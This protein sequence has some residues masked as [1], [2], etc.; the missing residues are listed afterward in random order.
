MPVSC[1]HTSV[2]KPSVTNLTWDLLFTAITKHRCK[3]TSWPIGIKYKMKKMSGRIKPPSLSA[4]MSEN[5]KASR[6][7]LCGSRKVI[8]VDLLTV[9]N[10]SGFGESVLCEISQLMKCCI[11]CSLRFQSAGEVLERIC[12]LGSGQLFLSQRGNVVSL[13]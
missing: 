2:L 5:R 3:N 10:F 13:L 8:S 7:W 9:T 4:L 1:S 6:L 11:F 12:E